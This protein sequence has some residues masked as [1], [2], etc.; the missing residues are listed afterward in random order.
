MDVPEFFG[1]PEVLAD[2]LKFLGLLKFL[3]VQR[4]SGCPKI[5]VD[6]LKIYL[7]FKKLLDVLK[8]R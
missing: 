6:V 8:F 1:C 5:S 2:V 7:V 4:F 3:G